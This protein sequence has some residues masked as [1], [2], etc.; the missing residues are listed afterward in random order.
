MGQAADA[1][2]VVRLRQIDKLFGVN[3]VPNAPT[4]LL[5]TTAPW[6]SGGRSGE[7]NR[8]GTATRP[9]HG[10]D[11]ALNKLGPSRLSSGRKQRVA[12]AQSLVMVAT[13]A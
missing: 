6:Y 4:S 1:Q 3:H 13:Y 2:T 8:G 12:I 5:W 10:Q 11:A 7:T 9:Q